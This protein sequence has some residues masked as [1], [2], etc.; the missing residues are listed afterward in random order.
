MAMVSSAL[1]DDGMARVSS[2]RDGNGLLCVDGHSCPKILPKCWTLVESRLARQR[3]RHKKVCNLGWWMEPSRIACLGH[4]CG[5]KSMC[6]EKLVG[7]M[8]Y[9]RIDG[10]LLKTC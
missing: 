4:N 8:F 5:Y 3:S 9:F 10:K 6:L 2:A 7:W 1:N